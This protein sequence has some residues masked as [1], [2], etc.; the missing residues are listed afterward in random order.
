MLDIFLMLKPDLILRNICEA[1]PPDFIADYAGS[2]IGIEVTRFFHEG[3]GFYRALDAYRDELQKHLIHLH[4]LSGIQ[5]AHTSVH[6][7]QEARLRDRVWRESLGTALM[8]FVSSHMPPLDVNVEHE[9]E[10]LPRA[11]QGFDVERISILRTN[12]LTKPAWVFPHTGRLPEPTAGALRTIIAEKAIKIASYQ[13]NA[14]ST[15]LLIVSGAAGI[16]SFFSADVD[17]L[18]ASYPSPFSRIFLLELF[19]SKVVELKSVTTSRVPMPGP[20]ILR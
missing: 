19:G 3:T 18:A 10:N 17:I 5:I 9:F 14:P 8:G 15:W 13:M 6:L 1:D 7:A 11:L 20:S 16:P 4:T 12:S 2:R